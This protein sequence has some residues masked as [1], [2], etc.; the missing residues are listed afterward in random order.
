[1]IQMGESLR[2]RNLLLCCGIHDREETSIVHDTLAM[3]W[4]RYDR[5]G[6]LDRQIQLLRIKNIFC[7]KFIN[8]GERLQNRRGGE[9]DVP[10]RMFGAQRIR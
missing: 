3:S 8:S 10:E 7:M 1:M 5:I 6:A 2:T 9:K 4:M